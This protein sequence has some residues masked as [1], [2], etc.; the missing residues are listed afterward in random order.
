MKKK[1]MLLTEETLK[2]VIAVI[3]I[4]L[5]VYLLVSI[6]YAG[7]NEKKERAARASI[8]A[9]SSTLPQGELPEIQ[10]FGWRLFSFVGEDD[11][12]NSCINQ[13]CLCICRKTAINVFNRQ[14]K[15]CDK[16]TACLIVSNLK[17]FDEIKIERP[18]TGIKINETNGQIEIELR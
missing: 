2:I 1:A 17:K 10:P 13:N 7:T 14:I 16:N 6:Y 5:L 15:Q 4:A 9:I 3:G 18:L 12:P 11:K 8:E